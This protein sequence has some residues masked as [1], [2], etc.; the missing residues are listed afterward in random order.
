MRPE[1]TRTGRACPGYGLALDTSVKETTLRH[2]VGG[3]EIADVTWETPH[4]LAAEADNA[5]QSLIAHV[6][7]DPLAGQ[8]RR[9]EPGP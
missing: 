1:D 3:D 2:L 7:S 4:D 6:S 9:Q 8:R 5:F